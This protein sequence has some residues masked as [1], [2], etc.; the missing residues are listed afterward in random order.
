MAPRPQAIL[1]R[2]IRGSSALVRDLDADAS[3]PERVSLPSTLVHISS[4]KLFESTKRPLFAQPAN[5]RTHKRNGSMSCSGSGQYAK[6][7]R[8]IR[9][10]SLRD[11]EN[12]DFTSQTARKK[13][14]IA[15]LTRFLQA[16]RP[17]SFA[18]FAELTICGNREIRP[19]RFD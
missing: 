17:T 13:R 11:Y 6:T 8:C 16:P 3:L 9:F 19:L 4:V 2:A 1:G 5:F 12:E 7:L 15:I 10:C 14:S 18:E